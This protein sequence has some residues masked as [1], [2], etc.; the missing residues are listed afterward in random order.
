MPNEI[1][2]R[3]SGPLPAGKFEYG[4][5]CGRTHFEKIEKGEKEKTFKC[6]QCGAKVMAKDQKDHYHIFITLNQ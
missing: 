3:V 6:D 2:L 4:C 1:S 5:K